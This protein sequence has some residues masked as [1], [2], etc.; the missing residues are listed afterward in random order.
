MRVVKP[1]VLQERYQRKD[2]LYD[3]LITMLYPIAGKK[4][5]AHFFFFFSLFIYTCVHVGC[6]LLA[7]GWLACWLAAIRMESHEYGIKCVCP[8]ILWMRIRFSLVSLFVIT[9]VQCMC[10]CTSV[11]V[12]LCVLGMWLCVYVYNQR[13]SLLLL[14][15]RTLPSMLLFLFQLRLYF[16]LLLL[17]LRCVCPRSC[18]CC[19]FFLTLS[20]IL[21]SLLRHSSFHFIFCF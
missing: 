11:S 5:I 16:I 14:L 8:C 12:C 3:S 9:V 1:H 7:A 2:C 20:H 17:C 6:L 4:I 15:A 21:L 19:Y 18:F 10:E 13:S